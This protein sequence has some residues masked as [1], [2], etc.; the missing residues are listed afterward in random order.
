M[1]A[2]NSPPHSK[3]DKGQKTSDRHSAFA[4]NTLLKMWSDYTNY[5]TD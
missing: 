2:K 1:Q 5:P 4:A 3:H